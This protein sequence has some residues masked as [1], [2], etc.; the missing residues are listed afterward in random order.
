M[1]YSNIVKTN[2]NKSSTFMQVIDN[3][4]LVGENIAFISSDH[5]LT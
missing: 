3:E 2:P 5:K 1:S 4:T